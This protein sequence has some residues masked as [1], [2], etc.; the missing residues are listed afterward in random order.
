MIKQQLIIWTND[1]LSNWH[2]HAS[3]GLNELKQY[4][5]PHDFF[6]GYFMEEQSYIS[7]KSELQVKIIGAISPCLAASCWLKIYVRHS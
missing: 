6:T 3:L 7:I 5:Y 2:I 1:G 4:N